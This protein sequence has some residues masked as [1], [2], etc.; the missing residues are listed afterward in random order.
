MLDVRGS[1]SLINLI[2]CGCQLHKGIE[3]EYKRFKMQG[4]MDLKNPLAGSLL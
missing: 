3:T 4:K 2:L 1:C